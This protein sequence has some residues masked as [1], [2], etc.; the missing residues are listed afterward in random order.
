MAWQDFLIFSANFIFAYSLLHQVLHGFKEKKGYLT[1][2]TASLSA[3]GLY[4]IG[5]ALFTLQLYFSALMTILNA[6]LWSILFAQSIFY[7]EA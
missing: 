3:L 5:F 7:K 1:L 6:V 2:S 4:T